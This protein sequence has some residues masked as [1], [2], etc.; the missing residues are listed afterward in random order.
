MHDILDMMPESIKQTRPRRSYN[1]YQKCGDVG[2]T[3]RRRCQA[4]RQQLKILYYAISRA[5]PIGG[6]RQSTATSIYHRR[7]NYLNSVAHYNREPIR[8]GATVDKAVVKK[9]LGRLTRLYLKA[10][11][12]R[13]YAYLKDG[14]YISTE[15]A[16]A[17]YTAAVH[18]LE[19][20]EFVPIP[21]P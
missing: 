6:H 4:C 8:R 2:R 15:E 18:W 3:F 11:Q 5:R 10:E 21:F 12:E 16:V 1:T 7:A 17:I 13:Q 9:N 20:R 14:P 19:S